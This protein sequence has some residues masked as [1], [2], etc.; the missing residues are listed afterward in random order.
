[1]TALASTT[2]EI[3]F[4]NAEVFRKPAMQT[5]GANAS[6]TFACAV[7]L[8]QEQT[9]AAAKRASGT[10]AQSTVERLFSEVYTANVEHFLVYR[11]RNLL[12][13]YSMAC[14]RVE[15]TDPDERLKARGHRVVV[16]R[17]VLLAAPK[18]VNRGIRD[19][20]ESQLRIPISRHCSKQQ[21]RRS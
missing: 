3:G 4:T 17:E 9:Q 15:L 2:D 1:L 16:D 7:H 20:L 8:F 14:V 18:G 21:C 10:R 12:V 11:L 5:A 13:H 19:Y 6:L